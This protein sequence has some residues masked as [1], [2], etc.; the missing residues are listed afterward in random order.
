[1]SLNLTTKVKVFFT[2]L[3]IIIIAACGSDNPTVHNDPIPEPDE[4]T[5]FE[6]THTIYEERK[7]CDNFMMGQFDYKVT[8]EQTGNKAQLKSG[9]QSLACTIQADELSCEGTITSDNGNRTSYTNY[10]LYLNND[11]SLTG[12]AEWTYYT[13]NGNFS[14]RSDLTTTQ[15]AEGSILIHNLLYATYQSSNLTPCGSNS[16]NPR[17]INLGYDGYLYIYDINPGCYIVY[18]CEDPAPLDSTGCRVSPEI[19]VNRAETELL[20]NGNS[21]AQLSLTPTRDLHFHDPK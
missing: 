10:T 11:K 19:T 14:G 13:Q 20:N 7:E 2:V 8:I 4:T 15:P 9:D 18:I 1:M 5:N 6:G 21:A 17:S 16:W 12:S 3:I